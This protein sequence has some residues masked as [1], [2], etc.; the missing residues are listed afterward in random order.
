LDIIARTC[1]ILKTQVRNLTVRKNYNPI[2]KKKRLLYAAAMKL[3]SKNLT[4]EECR[5]ELLNKF[6]VAPCTKTLS[7]WNIENKQKAETPTGSGS[8]ISTDEANHCVQFSTSPT[9]AQ[10]GANPAEEN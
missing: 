7:R 9:S 2:K 6:G 5:L 4:Y 3:I 8:E 1:D 10:E